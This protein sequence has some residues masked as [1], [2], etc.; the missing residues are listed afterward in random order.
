M[1]Y[2]WMGERMGKGDKIDNSI[3]RKGGPE[4]SLTLC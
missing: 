2:P 3:D 4:L 1:E